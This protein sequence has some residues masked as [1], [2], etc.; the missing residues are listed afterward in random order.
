MPLTDDANVQPYSE[1]WWTNYKDNWLAFNRPALDQKYDAWVE[2]HVSY[3][4][5]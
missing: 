3:N 1:A 5:Q 4:Q 2:Q